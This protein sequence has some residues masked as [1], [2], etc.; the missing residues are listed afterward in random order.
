MK[1]KQFIFSETYENYS[2]DDYIKQNDTGAW[3]YV[4]TAK[5]FSS[6]MKQ[7]V[8]LRKAL[9]QYSNK[10]HTLDE[11]LSN[12]KKDRGY[13]GHLAITSFN[14]YLELQGEEGENG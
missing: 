13:V 10:T 7:A 11:N 9:N 14:K 4:V 3:Y 2:I 12:Y 8:N 6:L 1:A 5:D